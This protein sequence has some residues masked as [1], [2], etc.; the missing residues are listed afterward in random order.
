MSMCG[1]GSQLPMSAAALRGSVKT[2]LAVLCSF[3]IL[4]VFF[5]HV[6]L[7]ILFFL[8]LCVVLFILSDVH[9]VFGIC[10]MLLV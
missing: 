1:A 3:F 2:R 8:F 5:L 9:T 4:F 7:V 6:I 10:L